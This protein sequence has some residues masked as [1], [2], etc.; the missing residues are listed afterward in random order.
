MKT[1]S[2]YNNNLKNSIRLNSKM[3]KKVM[4]GNIQKKSFKMKNILFKNNL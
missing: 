1:N 3:N 2:Y 4:Y